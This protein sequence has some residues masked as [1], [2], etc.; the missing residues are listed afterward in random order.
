[1]AEE[2]MKDEDF[3]LLLSG[4]KDA[5]RHIKGQHIDGITLKF[6]PEIDT[7]SMREKLGMSQ[8]EFSQKFGIAIATLRDWEQGRKVPNRQART[9]LKLIYKDPHY[10][11]NTLNAA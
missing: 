2:F 1:M 4:V 10:V 7:K 8:T 5:V 9:L 3:V 11:L 6:P